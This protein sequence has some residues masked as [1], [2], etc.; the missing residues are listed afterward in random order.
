MVMASKIALTGLQKA[1]MLLISLG[2]ECSATILT[3]FDEDDIERLTREISTMRVVVPEVQAELF[4]ECYSRIGSGRE[5]LAGGHEYARDMLVRALGERKATEL[6][7][8]IFSN[9]IAPFVFMGDGDPLQIANFL[10][11]EHPQT[12]AVVLSHLRARQAAAVLA[13]FEPELQRDIAVRIAKMDRIA[14]EI[15]GQIEH[16]LQIKFASVLSQDYSVSGGPD[17]LVALLSEIGRSA[18]KGIIEYLES[19]DQALAEEIRGK[20]FVFEDISQ[21]DDQSIQRLLKEL[22]RSELAKALKST[23]DAVRELIFRNMSTRAR[24]MLEEEID[25]LGPTRLSAVE[26]AQRGITDIIRR[27]EAEDEIFI[28]RGQD[29]IIA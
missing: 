21:L 2:P 1:A 3:S 6:L 22:D 15:L 19:T 8:R 12:V 18:E 24:E 29:Q 5:A 28:A 25:L 14:P 9:R 16:G 13:N 23:T 10:R 20:M 4:A 17:F 27:L 11:D 7:E 26:R